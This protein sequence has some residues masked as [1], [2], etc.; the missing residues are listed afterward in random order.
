MEILNIVGDRDAGVL[1][2][3]LMM[4]RKEI[5]MRADR[6]VYAALDRLY[7]IA[8]SCISKRTLQNAAIYWIS[9]KD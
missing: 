3:I 6:D 5:L 9:E 4:T 1:I 2:E 7:C 8:F